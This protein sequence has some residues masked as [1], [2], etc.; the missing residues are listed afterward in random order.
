MRKRK[1]PVSENFKPMKKGGWAHKLA[2]KSKI[3]GILD[4][5]CQESSIASLSTKLEMMSRKYESFKSDQS[6]TPEFKRYYKCRLKI[7]RNWRD[8]K[9]EES[10]IKQIDVNHSTIDKGYVT[11]KDSDKGYSNLCIAFS[12]DENRQN[13]KFKRI[14]RELQKILP[15][16]LY[17]R[18]NNEYSINTEDD[19]SRTYIHMN[20][21]KHYR[22]KWRIKINPTD[23]GIEFLRNILE[24]LVERL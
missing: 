13:I 15:P 11:I 5:E 22:G 10:L 7:V 19:R 20:C 17:I 6:I 3:F 2:R 16:H 23:I 14:V 1:K 8:L 18:N 24:T 21:Y 9:I 12:E 4:K